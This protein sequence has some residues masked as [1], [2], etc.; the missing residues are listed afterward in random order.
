MEK[1][2]ELVKL[3]ESAMA[4]FGEDYVSAL[5]KVVEWEKKNRGLKG[6]H[7]SAPLDVMCGVRK[8]DDPC[9]EAEKMAHDVLLMELSRA[10]GQLKE[11]TGEELDR[12]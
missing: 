5:D 7:V 8:I 1:D 12:M 3:I 10:R 9:S 11:V 4:E 6:L 2:E